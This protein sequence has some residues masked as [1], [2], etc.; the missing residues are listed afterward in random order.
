M[1]KIILTLCLVAALLAACSE[2]SA[3]P[4]NVANNGNT[5]AE[6]PA[7]PD[8]VTETPVENKVMLLKVNFQDYAFE[9][10]AEL[11]FPDADSFT[12][13]SDYQAPGDFGSITLN[14]A[15][16]GQPLFMGEIIWAGLGHMIYPCAMNTPDL[17]EPLQQAVEMPAVN[18][19]EKVNY[20][21]FAIYPEVIDYQSIWSAIDNLALVKQYRQSNPSAKVHLFLY[22]PGVG[23]GDPAEWDWYV[24]LKN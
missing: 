19:F 17:F 3:N 24:I 5:Q 13:S 22:T 8:P 7:N 10:G 20:D 15:E 9:G 23:V 6:A 4:V 18:S 1:K 14:Y 2:D 21:E 12:I 16:T 11:T